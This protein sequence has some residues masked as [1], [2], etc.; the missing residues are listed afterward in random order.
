MEV[1]MEMVEAVWRTLKTSLI[2]FP[3]Q[4]ANL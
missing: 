4:K 2:L 1:S 3:R